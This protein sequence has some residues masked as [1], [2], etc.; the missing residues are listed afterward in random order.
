M[1]SVVVELNIVF[2]HIG[3]EL[4]K[5]RNKRKRNIKDKIKENRTYMLT[6]LVFVIVNA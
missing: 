3:S 2:I 1:L 6:I 4:G 5:K